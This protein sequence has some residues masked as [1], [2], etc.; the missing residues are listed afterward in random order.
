MTGY[1]RAWVLVDQRGSSNLISVFSL[2]AQYMVAVVKEKVV[3]QCE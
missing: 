1:I 3:M 2:L